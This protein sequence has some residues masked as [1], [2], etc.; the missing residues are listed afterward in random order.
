MIAAAPLLTLGAR[1]DL[2]RDGETLRTCHV[3]V[4]GWACRYKTLEDGRRQITAF[5]LPG[6]LCD[7]Y[8]P[9]LAEMDH[10]LAT[11]TAIRYIE[12]PR[13]R[14]EQL[15]VAPAIG[16]ALWRDMLVTMAIQREW[17]VSIGQR[18]ALERL[19]H[20]LCE[21]FFRLRAAGL[22]RDDRCEFPLT[23]TDLAEAT[24]MT[25]VH[26]NRMVQELRSRGLIY[27]KGRVLEMLDLPGLCRAGLFNPTYLHQSADPRLA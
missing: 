16:R 18:D 22:V 24:G 21:L 27:W 23:Q 6:D 1:R 4:Q 19:A 9:L 8:P 3:I 17:T 7:L 20:M 25:P 15:V 26:V 10:S 11:I 12:L 14:V 13:D 2:L 5:V